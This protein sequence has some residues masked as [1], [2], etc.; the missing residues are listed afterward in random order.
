MHVQQAASLTIERLL[1][2]RGSLNSIMPDFY[3]KLPR[4]QHAKYKEICFGTCR[5]YYRLE[6]LLG[7][8]TEKPMKSSEYRVK[9]ILFVGLYQ[10]MS[11]RTPSHAVVNEAV[12]TA[13]RLNKPWARSLINAI[14]R[15]F[16]RSGENAVR[17]NLKEDTFKQAHPQWFLES[18]QQQFPDDWSSIIKV[19]NSHPPL[20]LRVNL[21]KIKRSDYLDQLSK[22][23]IPARPANI[24]PA[25]VY[26][27]QGLPVHQIPGFRDGVVS[28]QDESAQLAAYFLSP[29]KKERGLDACSAP[30]G[31]AGH[32]L[33]IEP[34][35]Q[36]LILDK[37][38]HRLQQLKSNFKRLQLFA[39][40]KVA[41]ASD[42]DSW[43][44][45]R[46]FDF[47]LLDAPCSGS[48][49]I[50]RNQ[51]I[52]VLLQPEQVTNNVESQEQLLENL[53][54]CVTDDGRLLYVTCSLFAEENNDLIERF[55]AKRG[56]CK[57]EKLQLS[58]DVP[59][60]VCSSGIQLL[61]NIDGGDGFFYSLLKKC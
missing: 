59:H 41:D 39:D 24:S 26:L 53:W 43:W 22:K 21:R 54:Q 58:P 4:V 55:T 31:K 49:V 11:M 27:L 20:C 33:E 17:Q 3:Q 44:D 14:L 34:S 35:I 51:D 2:G 9:A 38:D 56:D 60:K 52:R 29:Q 19:N 61:P 37:K 1:S 57:T 36:F 10:L 46:R 23:G 6:V 47:I 40:M 42:V 8:L 12:D 30:G 48:G 7:Q 50:R 45:G 28:I 32:L 18:I 13:R 5:W 15:E 25:G 16:S